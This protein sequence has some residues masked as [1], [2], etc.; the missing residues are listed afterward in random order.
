RRLQVPHPPVAAA[1]PQEGRPAIVARKAQRQRFLIERDGLRLLAQAVMGHGGVEG[2]EGI[3]RPFG[4]EL[5]EQ[6]EVLVQTSLGPESQG[7]VQ[8]G[9][10]TTTP[11]PVRHDGGTQTHSSTGSPARSRG[12]PHRTETAASAPDPSQGAGRFLRNGPPLGRLAHLGP[13]GAYAASCPFRSFTISLPA[14]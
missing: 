6:R 13:E 9:V 8:A 14:M 2:Q 4:P 1:Q 10:H 5:T 3:L 7:F 12:E 11:P